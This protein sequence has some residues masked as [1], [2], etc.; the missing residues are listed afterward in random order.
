MAEPMTSLESGVQ[1]HLLSAVL[2]PEQVRLDV[3]NRL[4]EEMSR[5]EARYSEGQV[6]SDERVAQLLSLFAEVHP[7]ERLF[8]F[9]GEARL[10][11]LAEMARRHDVE[12]LAEEVRRLVGLL[13][14]HR[15]RACLVSEV[16]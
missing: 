2:N 13:S 10:L 7:I 6:S 9:P 1:S 11:R 12:E 5:L 8:V 3:W 4:R 16:D 15:D 14:R